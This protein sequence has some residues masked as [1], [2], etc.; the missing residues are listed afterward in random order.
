MEDRGLAIYLFATGVLL[1]TF[2]AYRAYFD[3]LRDVPGPLL[4]RLTSLLDWYHSYVGDESKW[5]DTLHAKYGPVIRIAPNEVVISEG[6]AL[7]P[8]Y[9][10]K[11]GFLKAP[12][13]KN[14]D[15]EGHETIFSALDPKHRAVRS[16]AVMPMFSTANLRARSDAIEGCVNDLV[17]RLQKEANQSR[18]AAKETGKPSPVNVLQMSRR[19]AIDAVCSY[20]FGLQYGG[21]HEQSTKLSASNYVDSIVAFG[22]FFFL[23]TWLFQPI[24]LI[25]E[26]LQPPDAQSQERVEGFTK[27]LVSIS[28]ESDNTY[29]SRLLK[30]G[31]T[32]HETDVQMKDVIFAGTDT[33]GTNFGSL[34]F[35]L[36][37][38]PDVHATLREEIL[39]AEREDPDYNPQNLKYLDAVLREGL[40]TSMANPT[41]FP[42]Q[43]P[44]QGFLY[45]S[46]TTTKTYNLPAGTLVGLSPYTLHLNPAVFPDPYEFKPSRWLDDR[47][48]PEMYRDWIPFGLGPRQCIARNLAMVE[49]CLATRAVVR[50]GVLEGARPVGERLEV[51]EWFNA[52]VKGERIDLVWE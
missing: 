7:A 17:E 3:R 42:R 20:L 27:P 15:S 14:F 21:V 33:T 45:T 37:K 34:L 35:Q 49:L 24:L 32:E 1:A 4:C 28:K 38:H 44:P 25:S 40:R 48:T 2:V 22:R 5:I 16:K 26:Y 39:A 47:A 30:A 9:S 11:G 18:R 29:Q 41:R 13:Y 36:A 23:P 52:K 6:Q 50:S 46:L 10:E 8:I 19:L 12:C 43:V 31:I 51:F